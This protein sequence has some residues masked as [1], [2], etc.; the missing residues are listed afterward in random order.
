MYTITQN[1]GQYLTYTLADTTEQ[2]VVTVIPERGGIVTEWQWQGK[3]IFYLDKERLLDTALT[4]RGGIP[5]LF[6][7]C[8]GL[9]DQSYTSG[10]KVYQIPQHGFARNLPW[11]VASSST[12]NAAALT[13]TLESNV[14]T[15]LVYPFDF[16]LEFTYSLRG[17]NLA[18]ASKITNQSDVTMPFSLGFHPYFAA[19]DKTELEFQIPSS[20]YEDH[21]NNLT[22]S[23]QGEFDLSAPEIDVI[24]RQLQ[25]NTAVVKDPTQGLQMTVEMDDPSSTFGKNF[26]RHLVFWTVKDKNF[27]CLEPWSAARNALNT[28]TNLTSLEPGATLSATWQIIVSQLQ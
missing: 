6:P 3:E 23:F 11:T 13:V 28:E 14:Q 25:S 2:S 8:G 16:Q 22:F 12:D 18:I 4:V 10:G 24:F 20:A 21:Q 19:P 7:L 26:Y 5:I 9:P 1:Q 15:R 17:G 27:Y